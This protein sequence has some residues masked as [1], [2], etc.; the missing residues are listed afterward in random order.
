MSIDDIPKAALEECTQL[1]KANSIEGSKKATV[2]VVYTP[3]PNLKKTKDMEAGAVGY[4]NDK[5][6]KRVKVDKE[7]EILKRIAKSKK[8]R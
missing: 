5:A 1:V 3:F 2:H 8:E 4:H 7:K 6:V